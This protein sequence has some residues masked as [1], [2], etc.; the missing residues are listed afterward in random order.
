M[1]PV[2][3]AH[4][5]VPQWT[6]AGSA[7]WQFGQKASASGPPPAQSRNVIQRPR[8]EAPEEPGSHDRRRCLADLAIRVA[9]HGTYRLAAVQLAERALAGCCGTD[10]RC[11]RQ[12][13][14]TLA[15]AGDLL[16]AQAQL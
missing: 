4:R 5:H 16:S 13:V 1:P 6:V 7:G 11:V 10:P 8:T 12:A 15:Y 3:R 2:Q 14:L 9:H